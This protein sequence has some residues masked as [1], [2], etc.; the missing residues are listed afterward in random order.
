MLLGW[1]EEA[2]IFTDDMEHLISFTSIWARYIDDVFLLWTGT[3]Q[4]LE[5]LL[6][7]LNDNC[8]GLKFTYEYNTVSLPFL[9]VAITKSGDGKLYTTI[10]RKPTSTNSLLRWE[11]CH[12]E[13]LKRGIPKGQYLRLRR[14]CSTL[15]EYHKQAK[16]LQERF[17]DRGY[18]RKPLKKAYQFARAQNRETLLVPKPRKQ[19]DRLTRII[20]TYGDS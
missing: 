13:P 11:S 7:R 4:D 15:E 18:P 5:A 12:P 3:L 1:W 2:I 14:N 10:Y 8:I 16:D 9:D 19:E 6:A 20:G 17:L